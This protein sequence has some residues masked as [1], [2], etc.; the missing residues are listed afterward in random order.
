[1][2][3]I[4]NNTDTLKISSHDQSKCARIDE[5]GCS[6]LYKGEFDCI[7]NIEKVDH[8]ILFGNEHCD[9][10]LMAGDKTIFIEL[11]NTENTYKEPEITDI[12]NTIAPKFNG[13]LHAFTSIEKIFNKNSDKNRKINY[14]FYVHKNTFDRLKKLGGLIKKQESKFIGR[15]LKRL[16]FAAIKTCCENIYYDSDDTTIP[17]INRKKMK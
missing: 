6:F 10:I 17:L 14:I 1:V 8:N 15:E 4:S 7:I 16:E 3:K 12:I 13:T 2:I 5:N 9:V 11:K